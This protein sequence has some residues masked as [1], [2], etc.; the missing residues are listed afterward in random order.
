MT[1]PAFSYD[2]FVAQQAGGVTRC[3]LEMMR[4]LPGDWRLWSPFAE[5]W[6]LKEAEAWL[7]PHWHQTRPRGGGR[8]L[9]SLQ[10]E[11]AFARWLRRADSPIVHRTYYPILDLGPRQCKRV[12]TL[13]DMWD[14]R[15][16]TSRDRGAHVR[17]GI[18]RRACERA[19]R[20]ICVSEHTRQEM[21][22]FWPWAESK[23]VVI[24]HGVR[25]LGQSIPPAEQRPFFLFV[26][27]RGLYKNFSVALAALAAAD[28]PGHALVCFGGGPFTTEELALIHRH[29]LNGRV[30]QVNGTDAN[31]AGHYEAAVALLYPS[32]Y[33]GFGLPLL[34]AM[35]HDCP[36]LA[37]PLT[38]LPEVG[39]D[40]VLFADPANSAAW[41]DALRV[42]AQDSETA[43][44]LRTAGRRRATQFSWSRS[45]EA[46]QQVYDQLV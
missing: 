25:S 44:R 2:I 31:L 43:A 34:E 12:V 5:N 3:M 23:A 42:I 18:K 20:I 28:L 15:S 26:G 8:I 21:M 30:V 45:A 35:I 17:S 11:P 13:H 4:E 38:A 9:S 39:G 24:P 32:S 6:L 16:E 37:S 1:G 14:E 10:L 7:L 46:H 41:T 22:A 33:E 40:A 29:A 19:D 27:R 36:V